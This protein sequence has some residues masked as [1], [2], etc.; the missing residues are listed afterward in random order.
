MSSPAARILFVYN[1]ESSFVGID[2]GVLA[3]R[4]EVRDWRQQGPL[5]NLFALARAVARSDVVFGWFASWHTFWPVTLAWLMRKPSVVVIGGYDTANM[6]EI[7]YG[8]QCRGVMR[9]VSRWVMRR[10]TRLLTNSHYSRAEA[11]ANAGVDPERVSVVYHGVPDPFGELGSGARERMALTVGIVD[12]RNV[13]RKGLGAFVQAA[14]L[15]PDV[16]FVLAGRWDDGAADELRATATPNV[17]LTG[18]VEGDVLNDYYRRAS[19]YVQASAHE[20]FGLSVAE[21]M[22]AGCIPVTTRAGAL[23]EV[24]GDAGVQVEGQDPAALAAAIARALECGDDARGAARERVLRSFPLAIR[25]EGV[26]ALV[27]DTLARSGRSGPR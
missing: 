10:A 27:A 17:T 12:R 25:R 14:A 13:V 16:S 8:L 7:P 2:R 3:E 26:Q 1:R 15:L 18:W 5:V 6:P 4:W 20:G 21:G 19:V 24:V 22:L 23:P 9:L 11:A